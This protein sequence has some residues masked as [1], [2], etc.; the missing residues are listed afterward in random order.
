MLVVV[1]VLM[2]SLTI[3]LWMMMMVLM[4]VSM[5]TIA[6]MRTVWIMFLSTNTFPLKRWAELVSSAQFLMPAP[7]YKKVAST[8]FIDYLGHFLFLSPQHWSRQGSWSRCSSLQKS[9]LDCRWS[10]WYNR[11]NWWWP[12]ND[13]SKSNVHSVV[14]PHAHDQ[15]V[16]VQEPESIQNAKTFQ[17]W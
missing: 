14:L 4:L 12:S 9:P 17:N 3:T 8:R 2:L 7:T 6:L 5:M 15:S 16:S 10:S 11:F 13:P 1:F